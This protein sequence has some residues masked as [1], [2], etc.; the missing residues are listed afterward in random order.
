[1]MPIDLDAHATT[2]MLPEVRSVIGEILDGGVGNPSSRHKLGEASASLLTSARGHVA[3]LVDA[4]ADQVVFTSGATEASNIAVQGVVRRCNVFPAHI[5]ATRTEHSCVMNVLQF[6]ERSGAA[7]VTLVDVDRFGM[8]APEDIEAALTPDTALVCV[9]HGN[10]ELGTINPVDEI[11]R[12]LKSRSPQTTYVVD[13]AQTCGYGLASMTG[14]SADALVLSSHKMHGPTGVG[15]LCIKDRS[16]L[17]PLSFGGGQENGVRPGT[18]N[19]LG[20]VGFGKAAEIA[21]RTCRPRTDYVRGLRKSFW[22][23]VS[24]E[25]PE[26]I[27]NGHP[28]VRLPGNLNITVPGVEA[29]VLQARL[30]E[31]VA[32]SR[33]SA[34]QSDSGAL[35]HVLISIG[36]TSE[37]IACTFRVGVS[38]MNTASEVAGAAT[39]IADMICRLNGR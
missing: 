12:R 3:S 39:I 31:K 5:V 16:R 1:M 25:C 23:I 21:K 20:I 27:L 26:C 34:C 36:L 8:V 13:A 11:G 29:H 35:S 37:Q 6:M 30:R 18:Q 9:I 15:A 38:E 7:D 2:Q 22:D 19:V 10:N 17:V 24:T 33:G 28:D 32:F 14:S 4:S